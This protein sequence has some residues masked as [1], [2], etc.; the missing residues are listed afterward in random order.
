MKNEFNI[1]LFVSLIS[2]SLIFRE[3]PLV[4][5]LNIKANPRDYKAFQ[6]ILN[7]TVAAYFLHSQ[8]S[9]YTFASITTIIL[10]VIIYLKFKNMLFS[11]ISG[12]GLLF[13]SKHF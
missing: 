3:I 1:F 6:S 10:P 9:S 2:T 11:F 12:V 7:V 8:L 5:N 4:I 13:I